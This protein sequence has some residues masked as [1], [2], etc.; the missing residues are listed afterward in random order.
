MHPNPWSNVIPLHPAGAPAQAPANSPVAIGPDGRITGI[1]GILDQIGEAAARQAI[2]VLQQVVP[3]LIRNDIMPI[4]LRDKEMQR[5][6]GEAAGR[7][8][9]R[10]IKPWVILI[11][12]S[13]GVIAGVQVAKFVR[14]RRA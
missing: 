11:G 7:A 4:L 1:S 10:E 9:A 2:P 12:V 14:R 13:L 5:T 8:A 6:L 3:P